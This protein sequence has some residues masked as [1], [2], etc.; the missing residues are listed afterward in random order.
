MAKPRPPTPNSAVAQQS[1]LLSAI[2]VPLYVGWRVYVANRMP[3]T[4]CD[5]VFNYWEPLHFVL[6]GS[7]QQTWEYAHQYALRT[8]AYLLPLAALAKYAIQPVVGSLMPYMS[9][10]T[11]MRVTTDRLAIFMLLRSTLGATTALAELSFLRAVANH[12]NNPDM[13][14][15]TGLVLL[16]AAGMNH[17]AAA[18]LPSSTWMMAWMWATSLFLQT[19]HEQF[20]LVAVA[21]TLLIGWPFGVAMLVPMGASILW[22][23]AK[24]NALVSVLLFT[25]FVAVGIQGLAVVIDFQF[26]GAY[27]SPTLNIFTYNAAGG[28]DELYGVEP[29]SYYL[30]NLLLNLNILAPLG[31]LALPIG[32][33]AWRSK[34][35]GNI[36]VVL[37]SLILWL[38]ITLPRPHKEERFMF[39]IYPLL[40]FGAVFSVDTVIRGFLSILGKSIASRKLSILR[41]LHALIWIPIAYISLS[42]SYALRKYY[43]APL[44]VYAVINSYTATGNGLVCT[45][46]EWYRFP[47]SFY[48]PEGNQ[49]AF[50]P[51]SFK[52]QLPQPFSVN[53][54]KPESLQVLQPFNDRNEEQKER[55]VSHP[56]HCSWIVDL[57]GGDCGADADLSVAIKAT[58]PFLDAA[59]TETIHRTIYLPTLHEK[60]AMEDKVRYLDYIL[61]KVEES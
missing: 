33:L 30:K 34:P 17:A 32:L 16:T 38:A 7:G 52:G 28:G 14:L 23:E 6:Y 57:E 9:I 26:Y 3:I 2:V 10:L 12:L 59:K 43:G 51:S 11:D 50:L 8:Y 24:R 45:C 37:S 29:V 44:R 55:Y 35:L 56:K 41:L 47:S 22:K 48:L 58:A 39:P 15:W 25:L 19:K 54:S 46:G 21:S 31:L 40:I 49:L 5:E 53:G 27:L 42:R 20:I 60:A 18:F 4:D 36:L 13:A 1:W 61:Y